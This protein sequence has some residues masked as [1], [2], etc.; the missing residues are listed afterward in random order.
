MI[1]LICLWAQKLPATEI[2]V[3][4]PQNITKNIIDGFNYGIKSIHIKSN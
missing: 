1:L 2:M 3:N 4:L